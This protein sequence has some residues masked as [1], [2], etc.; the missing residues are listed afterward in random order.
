MKNRCFYPSC[1]VTIVLLVV[2][3][4]ACMQTPATSLPPA[5]EMRLLVKASANTDGLAADDLAQRAAQIAQLPVRYLSASGAGWHA[6]VLGCAD[7]AQCD[8]GLQRLRSQPTAFA[9]V[10]PDARASRGPGS[11]SPATSR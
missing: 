8:L 11:P 9:S 3:L 10:E 7:W 6:L 2:G 1:G 5:I 4:Q